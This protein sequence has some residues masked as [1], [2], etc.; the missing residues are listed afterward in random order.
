MTETNDLLDD[1]EFLEQLRLALGRVCSSMGKH[2]SF[3]PSVGITV[4]NH[5]P[6]WFTLQVR[7]LA[8]DMCVDESFFLVV[9]NSPNHSPD[10][11]AAVISADIQQIYGKD[12]EPPH[13]FKHKKVKTML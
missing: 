4:S 8:R 5:M 3:Y 6:L 12:L 1:E 9:R 11:M 2:W 7:Y 10:R 13:V